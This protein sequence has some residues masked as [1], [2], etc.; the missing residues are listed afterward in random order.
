MVLRSDIISISRKETFAYA[1]VGDI[2]TNDIVC[3]LP[4][5]FIG[6]VF[7]SCERTWTTNS[8]QD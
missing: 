8:R 5:V 3:Q 4:C 2:V 7:G 1:G 6:L